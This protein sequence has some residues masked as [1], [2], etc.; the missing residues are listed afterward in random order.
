MQLY[1]YIYRYQFNVAQICSNGNNRR[2]AKL[3]SLRAGNYPAL[4][5]DTHYMHACTSLEF[6]YEMPRQDFARLD[7]YNW[8]HRS[9]KDHGS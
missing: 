3:T 8:E 5:V 1:I 7:F 9:T 4:T 2:S 6:S